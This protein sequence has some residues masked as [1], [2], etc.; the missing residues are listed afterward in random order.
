[1]EKQEEGGSRHGLCCQV[2]PFK[3][4]SSLHTKTAW[5]TTFK[6]EKNSW[7]SPVNYFQ[8]LFGCNT[9]WDL[10]LLLIYYKAPILHLEK[11]SLKFNRTV[12]H[13]I[14]L[15]RTKTVAPSLTSCPWEVTRPR[16]VSCATERKMTLLPTMVLP[17]HLLQSKE[18]D[19][20]TTFTSTIPATLTR[21]IFNNL[22]VF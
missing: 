12:T 22:N 6:R 11:Q 4:S 17:A 3:E 19:Y 1:M 15:W 2:T 8:S 18:F 13:S 21:I 10:R 7:V 5:E 14:S 20:H 16:E 9:N